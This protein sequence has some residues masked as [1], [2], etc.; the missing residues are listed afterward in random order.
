[1]KFLICRSTL[2]TL[3]EKAGKDSEQLHLQHIWQLLL[4]ASTNVSPKDIM[5]VSLR[6]EMHK[7]VTKIS[8]KMPE[9]L[10]EKNTTC[11]Q[12][13]IWLG[14]VQNKLKQL[15]LLGIT[16]ENNL[17]QSSCGGSQTHPAVLLPCT[18]HH[19]SAVSRTAMVSVC[20]GKQAGTD[21]TGKYYLAVPV[22]KAAPDLS[23]LVWSGKEVTPGVT[24]SVS[25]AALMLFS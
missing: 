2:I 15:I 3:P 1:M 6:I 24:W 16:L 19:R 12:V 7:W 11:R 22:R 17:A 8:F 14:L 18:S 20:S 4:S 5:Y 13:S 25:F 10:I 23:C 21:V 9:E